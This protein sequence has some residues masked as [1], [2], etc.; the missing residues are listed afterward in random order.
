MWNKKGERASY[1]SII[2][3]NI[4]SN[5]LNSNNWSKSKMIK[6]NKKKVHKLDV[7]ENFKRSL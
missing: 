4:T 7:W 2:K 3:Q 6:F 1:N 5:K